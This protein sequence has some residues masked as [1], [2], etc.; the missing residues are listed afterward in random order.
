M[1]TT[2]PTTGLTGGT[3]RADG[4]RLSA[5][6]AEI[7]DAERRRVWPPAPRPARRSTSA[8]CARC[9]WACRRPSRPATPIRS[10]SSAARA[11]RC[12]TSTPTSTPTSTAGFGVGRH[13]PRPSQD[14]R[15]HHPRRQHRHPLRRARRPVTVALAEEL[16]RRFELDQVRFANSGTE[17]TMDAIRIARA[18]T[19]RDAGG[20]DRGLV[21]RSPRHGHVLG[22][23]QRRR[24]RRPRPAR[25]HPHVGRHPRRHGQAHRGGAVQ[26]RGR[27]RGRCCRAG[28]TRWPA[29]SSS[30]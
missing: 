15:G 28:A 9:P 24:A 1:S 2:D 12:G 16:C 8:P 13:R 29:S 22:A 27:L 19:G 4:D 3:T 21:P 10:T 11:R 26:R 14:R 6:A 30:R 18:A 25:H 17:A 7:A 20:Q 5:R 23:A